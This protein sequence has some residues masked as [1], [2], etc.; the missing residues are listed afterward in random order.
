MKRHDKS[1]F[2][3]CNSYVTVESQSVYHARIQGVGVHV[4]VTGRLNT[5]TKRSLCLHFTHPP[6][7]SPQPS[8]SR[9]EERPVSFYQLGSNQLPSNAASLARDVTGLAKD[10]Q[11]SFV[12]SILQN[13]TYG[14]ILSGSPPPS[15]PAAPSTTSAPPLPPRNVA[16]G[17]ACRQPCRCK[18]AGAAWGWALGCSWSLYTQ[19]GGSWAASGQRFPPR[20][21]VL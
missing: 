17:T 14:A 12:P 19:P 3:S 16:K 7:T 13:E 11:R 5:A 1:E 20:P 10:K 15:Q 2:K 9:R 18:A 8:P 21:F 4:V 6:A